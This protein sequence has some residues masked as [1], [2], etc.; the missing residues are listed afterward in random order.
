MFHG[1]E[2]MDTTGPLPLTLKE[3]DIITYGRGDW[4]VVR[5]WWSAEWREQ[6][7]AIYMR[8]AEA[9]KCLCNVFH[10]GARAVIKQHV[11][12]RAL[13]NWLPVRV[14]RTPRRKE[15]CG[16]LTTYILSCRYTNSKDSKHTFHRV[17]VSGLQSANQVWLKHYFSLVV[18][19]L[20]HTTSLLAVNT[21]IIAADLLSVMTDGNALISAA[22][23]QEDESHHVTMVIYPPPKYTKICRS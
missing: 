12:M 7:R 14:C 16:A 19:N 2:Q 15:T 18:Q 22:K 9:E 20:I 3:H 5:E 10:G 11:W 4:S 6:W 17:H 1:V 21:L 23:Q 8:R 13:L